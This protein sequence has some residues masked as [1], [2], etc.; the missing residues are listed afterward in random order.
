MNL[1]SKSKS[2]TLPHI[3]PLKSLKDNYI[4][5]MQEHQGIV[6]VVD[7]GDPS[8]ILEYLRRF[9]FNQLF[10]LITHHHS[11]HTAGL[12]P[13]LNTYPQSVAFGPHHDSFES[14]PRY[15]FVID[16]QTIEHYN[17][18]STC[19]W[20]VSHTPGHT[21]DH[22]IFYDPNLEIMFSGDTLFSAGCGRIFE[23]T[24]S[25]MLASLKKIALFPS[26]TTIYPAHEYTFKNLQFARFIEP[27]N[28]IIKQALKPM[29]NQTAHSTPTLPTTLLKEMKINP[30]LRVCCNYSL[31][32]QETFFDDCPDQL[33][34][35]TKLRSKKDQ[36]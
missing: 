9:T 10:V 3:Y 19:Q 28:T 14:P 36:F 30:F 33:S 1:N 32:R 15:R 8:V 2:T 11:D 13:L 20:Q 18:D 16:G 21:L 4:W 27:N 6:W 5:V 7:P 17:P 35:F 23:G 24:P 12:L 34:A 22:L 25:M 26:T 31:L 29:M